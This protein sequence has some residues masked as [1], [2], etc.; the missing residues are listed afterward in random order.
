MELSV[1]PHAQ[2]ALSRGETWWY[3]LI[4]GLVATDGITIWCI[5]ICM[6]DT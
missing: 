6:L 2:A 1:Q 5:R 3:H 4:Q